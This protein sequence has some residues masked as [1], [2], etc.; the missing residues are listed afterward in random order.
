MVGYGDD[1][2]A[3]NNG[4]VWRSLHQWEGRLLYMAGYPA[5]PNFRAPGGWRLSAGAV[6]IPPPPVGAA[7]D[8]AINEVLETMSDEQRAEPRFFRDNY[9]AW[10]GF[11][12]RRYEQELIAYDGP[13]PPPACNNATDRRHWWSTPGRTFEAVLAHIEGGNYPILGMPPPLSLSRHRGS[14]WMPRRMASRSSGSASSESASHSSVSMPRMVKQEPPSA[15][16]TRGCSSGALVIREGARTSSLPAR[17][18]KQ[19]PRKKDAVAAAASDLATMEAAQVEDAAL[20]EAIVR[21]LEDLVP[22]E[23]SM[24]MDAVLAWSRQDWE[25]EE[26]EQRWRL[27]DLAVA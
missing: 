1:D 3:A 22:S 26:A 27:L 8:A 18:R 4:F 21:S 5:P 25:R 14:S 15:S 19:K 13:S 20:H 2:R 11:F 23:N 10:N 16:S 12:R 7:L 6:P 17:G 9:P 24:P